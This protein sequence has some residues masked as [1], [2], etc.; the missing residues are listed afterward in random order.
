MVNIKVAVLGSYYDPPS[1]LTDPRPPYKPQFIFLAFIIFKNIKF[2]TSCTLPHAKKFLGATPPSLRGDAPLIFLHSLLFYS[3]K[4][5]SVILW[6]VSLSL[7][8]VIRVKLSIKLEDDLFI[9][10]LFCFE[11]IK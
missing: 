10:F 5:T 4:L 6:V 8:G 9:F 11:L 1:F 7:I 2:C 3:S